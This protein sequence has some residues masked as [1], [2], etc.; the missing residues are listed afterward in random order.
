MLATALAAGLAVA[1]PLATGPFAPKT[2]LRSRTN[3]GFNPGTGQINPGVEHAAPSNSSDIRKIPTHAE[4]VVALLA[5][6]DPNPAPGQAL[7]QASGGGNNHA[8]VSAGAADRPL[9][10]AAQAAIGGPLSPGASSG[11]SNGATAGASETTGVRPVSD[12]KPDRSGPI[13]ATGQT[14]PAKFSKEMMCWTGCR[15]WLGRCG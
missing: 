9:R 14:M 7:P 15:S 5:S 12:A 3:L 4:A 2:A 8:T 1:A 13:G 6:D 11:G 10:P